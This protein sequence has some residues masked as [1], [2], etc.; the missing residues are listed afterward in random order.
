MKQD[1]NREGID[2]TS[3][4]TTTIGFVQTHKFGG[5]SRVEALIVEE[6]GGQASEW[7]VQL[8][9]SD[10]FAQTQSV[11]TGTTPEEFIPDQNQYTASDTAQLEFVTTNQESNSETLDVGV[12]VDNNL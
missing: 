11:T 10:L 9:G 8:D 2:A 12:L 6:E 5:T 3:R 1:Y 4:Q 7:N